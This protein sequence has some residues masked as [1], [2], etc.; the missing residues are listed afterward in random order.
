[1]NYIDLIGAVL[2][3]SVPQI[4]SAVQAWTSRSRR[5]SN[6]GQSERKRPPLLLR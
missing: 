1:M 2:V 4:I 5:A 6:A 3:A